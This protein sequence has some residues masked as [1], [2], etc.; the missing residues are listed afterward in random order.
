MLYI[1]QAHK[2][3]TLNFSM[4]SLSLC[5]STSIL[6][7]LG[8][9]TTQ[10]QTFLVAFHRSEHKL[11][12]L[13]DFMYVALQYLNNKQNLFAALEIRS[14][15]QK[16]LD[17]CFLFHFKFLF[18][19]MVQLQCDRHSVPCRPALANNVMSWLETSIGTDISRAGTEKFINTLVMIF[20]YPK[21][22]FA[23]SYDN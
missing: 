3:H 23:P 12:L 18:E 22:L 2:F 15:K 9:E 14:G 13:N 21:Y 1:L 11:D 20:I 10:Q 8:G 19:K 6:F 5:Y 7:F 16:K 17:L 4:F